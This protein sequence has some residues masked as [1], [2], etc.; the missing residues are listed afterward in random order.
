MS[1]S[2]LELR[3]IIESG[4]LPL[5]CRCTAS[6]DGE[7]TLEVIDPAS[8]S[9]LMMGGISIATLGTSRAIA[10]LIAQVKSELSLTQ[11]QR[12]AFPLKR[13]NAMAGR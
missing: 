13:A 7:L 10:E 2:L 11:A 6:T 4:F 9:N 5:H 8:G 3:H 1:I 12:R